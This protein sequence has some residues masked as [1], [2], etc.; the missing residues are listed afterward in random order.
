MKLKTNEII[1]INQVKFKR[2]KIETSRADTSIS[3]EDQ[4]KIHL[5]IKILKNIYKEYK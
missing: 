3:S 1:I 2:A 5:I 4:K